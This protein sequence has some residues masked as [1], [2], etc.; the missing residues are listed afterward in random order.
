MKKCCFSR[1]FSRFLKILKFI[2]INFVFWKRIVKLFI[3]HVPL[4]NFRGNELTL[5]EKKLNYKNPKVRLQLLSYPTCSLNLSVNLLPVSPMY[6]NYWKKF[7]FQL[8]ALLMGGAYGVSFIF[9]VK[10]KSLFC[11]PV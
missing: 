5:L 3:W 11:I 9:K 6:W 10:N 8:L 1:F 4:L 7:N 2:F